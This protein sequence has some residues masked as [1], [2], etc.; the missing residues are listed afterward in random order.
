MPECSSCGQYVSH[1]MDDYY[2][3]TTQLIKELP[4]PT[5]SYITKDGDDITPFIKT[6]YTWVGNSKPQY[7]P[8]NIVARALLRIKDLK[9]QDL[10]F[11]SNRT[12]DGQ[13]SLTTETRICCLR[14]FQ[15]DPVAT[16][17]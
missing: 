13:L 8:G 5:G 12:T 16:N 7:M 15:T 9:Q 1:L 4:N 11:G 2:K 10:P 17:N 6:Y 3:L 14:M